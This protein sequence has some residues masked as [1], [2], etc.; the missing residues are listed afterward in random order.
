MHC[1]ML[2][3]DYEISESSEIRILRVESKTAQYYRKL[4]THNFTGSTSLLNFMVFV[5]EKI[6]GVFGVDKNALTIGSYGVGISNAVFLMYGMT[7][8]HRFYRLNRLLTM[9]VQNKTF[10]M[11]ICTDL[12]YEKAKFLKTVQMT[13]YPE[14][15]EMRGIMKL[16]E[17]KRDSRFGYRLIYQSELKDRTAEQTLIEWLRK[18]KKWQTERAKFKAA[19]K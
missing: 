1:P 15:K 4:R 3:L 2:P 6:A 16:L 11:S 9:L 7:V 10:I 19:Q 17:R 12:E 18:E 14:A 13:K 5:D 8:P